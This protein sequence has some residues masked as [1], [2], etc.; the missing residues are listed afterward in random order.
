MRRRGAC[1][2]TLGPDPCCSY[3]GK[4]L[5]AWDLDFTE[6]DTEQMVSG[7]TLCP[8]AQLHG[9]C[10]CLCLLPIKRAWL[11]ICVALPSAFDTSNP[12]KLPDPS[13]APGLPLPVDYSALP[14]L[15]QHPVPSPLQ[16]QMC[17]DMFALSGVVDHFDLDPATLGSF[18]A[19]VA[20]HY[21]DVPYHNLN[22]AVHV[23][24]GTWMV[25]GALHVLHP[26][27]TLRCTRLS[28]E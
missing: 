7:G 3:G 27:S 24:H 23:L 10:L 22:H 26:R 1:A 5:D 9:V 15:H 11:P 13:A 17:H 18:F 14:D 2:I 8:S 25:R 16:I 21:R 4:A 28:L 12:A 19:A 20:S 6:A